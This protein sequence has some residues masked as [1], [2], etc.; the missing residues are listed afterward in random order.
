MHDCILPL[1]P[2]KIMLGG[3]VMREKHLF[4]IIRKKVVQLLNGYIQTES[5][6]KNI[7]EYIVPPALGE[8]AGILG[9]LALCFK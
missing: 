4:P 5:I 8:D 1:S 9:A 3:G 2:E 6:L 7:D